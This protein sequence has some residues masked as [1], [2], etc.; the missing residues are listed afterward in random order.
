MNTAMRKYAITKYRVC[1]FDV[2][3]EAEWRIY[4]SVG[5]PSLF[6]I[7]ACRLVGAKTLSEPMLKY[8]LL[9]RPLATHFGDILSIRSFYFQAYA[10]ENI[11]R[12]MRA[13]MSRSQCVSEGLFV[14]A[15]Q[16]E[17]KH[18]DHTHLYMIRSRLLDGVWNSR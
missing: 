9:V 12:K 4:A 1:V 18:V 16:P 13:I 7:M 3:F 6:R 15:S 14:F 2:G 10:F 5:L 17:W 11:V 8:C